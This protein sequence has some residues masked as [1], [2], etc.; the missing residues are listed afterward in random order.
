MEFRCFA[1]ARE[2]PDLRS[3]LRGS[4]CIR[5]AFDA[6][7]IPRISGMRLAFDPAAALARQQDILR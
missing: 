7:K 5:R 6:D 1:V 2:F 3:D 4:Y